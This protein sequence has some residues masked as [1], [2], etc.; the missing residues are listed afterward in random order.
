MKKLAKILFLTIGLVITHHTSAQRM[1]VAEGSYTYVV[2]Q[3]MSLDKAK[4]VALEHARIKAIADTYGTFVGMT[5]LIKTNTSNGEVNAEMLSFGETE[6]KGEWLETIGDPEYTIDFKDDVLIVSVTVKG[7][8]REICTTEVDFDAKILKNG[9]QD[10]H[11]SLDFKDNDQLYMSFKSPI[12]GYLTIYLHD[13]E[14]NVYCLLPYSGQDDGVV[15]IDAKKRYVLFSADQPHSGLTP[16]LIDEYVMTCSKQQEFNRIYIMFSP[17]MF[18]KA[19]DNKAEDEYMPRMLN[20][21]SFQ[22]WL[23]KCRRRDQQ[24]RVDVRTISISK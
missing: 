11:E 12:D 17:N 8:I 13:G 20:F 1:T 14:D 16:Y 24:M 21:Q 22:K 5:D 6:V 10:R 9:V 3:D 4:L 2:P 23:V 18:T 15:A 19:L 7:R